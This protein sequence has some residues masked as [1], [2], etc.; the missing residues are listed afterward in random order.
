MKIKV[1]GSKT[2]LSHKGPSHVEI[3]GV[4][5]WIFTVRIGFTVT[6]AQFRSG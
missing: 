5:Q 1:K 3:E 2:Y 6:I 4:Q